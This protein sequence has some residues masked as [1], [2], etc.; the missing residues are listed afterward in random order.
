MMLAY[1]VVESLGTMLVSPA[2]IATHGELWGD[3]EEYLK[4]LNGYVTL[5]IVGA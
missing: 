2:A 4:R 1:P 3:Y 5:I